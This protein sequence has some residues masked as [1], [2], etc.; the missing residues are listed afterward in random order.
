MI[1]D[2]IDANK[3]VN[4]TEM[5][6]KQLEKL[7]PG[8]FHGETVDLEYIKNQ[9][10]E[11]KFTKEGY[12]LNFLGKSYAKLLAALDTE[13]VIV[14]D[15]EHNEKEENKSSENLYITADNLDALKHLLK[16]YWRKV[17]M[18]YI[19]PPYNTGSDG[20]AYNDNFNFTKEILVE[21]L[22]LQE[23]DAERVVAMTSEGSSTHSAWLTFMYPRLYL[24]KQL[25][26]DDGVIFI[27]IDDNEFSNLKL[28]CDDV[29]GSNN[30]METFHIQVRYGNKSLNEKDDFQKLI[31]Y[32][33]IYAKDRQQFKP[34]KETTEY[35]I[36][37]FNLDVKELKAPDKTETINGRLVDIF[38]PGSFLINEVTLN[39][40]ESLNF[41]KETW[42][43]GSIYSGTGHG[44]VYQ[45]V[46]EPRGGID[47]LGVLYKIYGLGEDG[48][49]YRYMTG[50]QKVNAKYGKMYNKVPL[51][52]LEGL[53]SGTF[54]KTVPILNYYDFSPDF[55]NI[56]HEG[57]VAFNSGKKPIKFLKYLLSIADTEKDALILDFFSGSASTAHAV[58]QQNLED[59]GNR[60]FIMVQLSETPSRESDAYKQ[61]FKTI[62]ELGIKRI[63]NCSEKIRNEQGLLSTDTDLGFKH[64][65]VK[66]ITNNQ[67][68]KLDTFN[69]EVL[70]ADRGVLDEFGTETVLTTWLNLDGY[71][72]S[73]KCNELKIGNYIAYQIDATVYL[74]FPD[75]SNESIKELL[76]KFESDSFICNKIILFGYSF[77]MSEI[78]SIK[79]N[80]KQVEGIRHITLDI[81]VRY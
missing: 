37:R 47:G 21:K 42:V 55:G 66:S 12:E 73:R 25:L 54:E 24:A 40:A 39:Q 3:N 4:A 58:M 38:L 31:E 35:D 28:L 50:P 19:D 16:S 46:V 57:G 56:R 1:K 9:L 49:G 33:L 14:P 79:D 67:L 2:I 5:K 71:G 76:E 22:G 18:I 59:N 32:T 29:F 51:N 68:T 74:L 26:T 7:F 48:L 13:T 64:F 34:K 60:R 17:K 78:Q 70:F 75:I 61:G 36:T 62:D 8:A 81:M 43:T 27:S 23:D 6:V 15:N 69:S 41:F 53:K 63:L 44:K 80:L 52:K 45:Q 65:T 77:T 11:V 30:H 10:K 72:L 20:F